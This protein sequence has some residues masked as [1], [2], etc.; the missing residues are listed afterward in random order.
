MFLRFGGTIVSSIGVDETYRAVQPSLA[1]PL[2]PSSQ[3]RDRVIPLVVVV[4]LGH[5]WLNILL[6]GGLEEKVNNRRSRRGAV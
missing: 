1:V 5:Q 4:T 2:A 6:V 3:V